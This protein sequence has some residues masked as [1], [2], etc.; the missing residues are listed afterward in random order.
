MT[1]SHR[2]AAPYLGSHHVMRGEMLMAND[3]TNRVA[4]IEGKVASLAQACLKANA[5]TVRS[6]DL[7]ER[8]R[9]ALV[10]SQRLT[11]LI[12]NAPRADD[13]FANAGL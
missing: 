8:A 12:A 13:A 4:S 2:F 7:L 3:L 5:S 1:L 11:G 10:L 9:T 6:R